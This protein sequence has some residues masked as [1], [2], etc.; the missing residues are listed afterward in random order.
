MLEGSN[1]FALGPDF[2]MAEGNEEWPGAAKLD[3]EEE[4]A[5]EATGST[6]EVRSEYDVD[7]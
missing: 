1:A 5:E 3:P 6:E 4:G 2:A 7:C